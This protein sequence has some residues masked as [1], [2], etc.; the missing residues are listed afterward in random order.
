[1]EALMQAM[2]QALGWTLIH[3]LWEGTLIALALW[4][5][6]FASA[7][8]RYAAASFAMLAM[9]A[10][11]ALTLAR[12]QPHVDRALSPLPALPWSRLQP[13]TG[14]SAPVPGSS[15]DFLQW[16]APLWMS[17][18]VLFSLRSIA[19]CLAAQ[20]LRRVG[21]CSAPE[22]WQR[23]LGQLAARIRLSRPVWLLESCL[24]DVPVV[25]G[26]L[27]PAILVPAGLLT[28]FPPA[29]VECFL[30]HELAHI[31][32]WDYLV[33]I[34]QC[35]A[36]DLL[37][38]HPA[39]WW[40]SGLIRAER[41]NCC[42]DVV[43]A[44]GDAHGFAAALAALE[45]NRSAVRQPALAATGG[46]L[47]NRVRRLLGQPESRRSI[48]VPVL[49]AGALVASLAIAIGAPARP[50]AQVPQIPV[51]AEPA[52]KAAPPLLAQAPPS[53]RP[54]EP[55][56]LD[57][58]WARPYRNWLDE[59]VVYIISDAE[60]VAFRRLRA[61]AELQYFIEQFWLRRDPTPGTPENEYREEHYRRIAYVNDRF[62]YKDVPGWKTERGAIYIRFGPPD[63]LESLG[64]TPSA[65]AT[66]RW[67]YR[68]IEGVGTSVILEF[69]DPTGTGEF[70]M[71]R[72]PSAQSA[73]APPRPAAPPAKPQA[74]A[75]P[76]RPAGGTRLDVIPRAAG[77]V[78]A[79]YVQDQ[80]FVKVGQPLALLDLPAPFDKIY[81]PIDGIVTGLT[82]RVGDRL[83]RGQR[84]LQ[85]T[86]QA[87][88][89]A[90][91]PNS[92]P[93]KSQLPPA[94]V[95]PPPPSA[96][97]QPAPPAPRLPA[98][99][100]APPVPRPP[101]SASVQAPVMIATGTDLPVVAITRSGQ[102]Y[103]NGQP[104]K[105][106]GL[107]AS[108]IRRKFKTNSVYLLGDRRAPYD[109]VVQVVSVLAKEKF[110]IKLVAK[111]E[112]VPASGVQERQTV[113]PPAAPAPAPLP[114]PPPLR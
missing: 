36:E 11:F 31:R 95:Q 84:L 96:P 78:V 69:I 52:Q 51:P 67:R 112:D 63:E 33:N 50:P 45:H 7:R 66:E 100:P 32:R 104:V 114:P 27:R 106:I 53:V 1:M 35:V 5:F 57:E 38:Y 49:L 85:I 13:A 90:S 97:P 34:L 2:P 73:P 19:S 47:V 68:Y 30:L 59:E 54:A 94:V 82:A 23:K 71:T 110:E 60:R 91:A 10:A 74:A 22:H 20:R 92:E 39:V 24:T 64:A 40:V 25:V 46:R 77:T 109:A 6:R 3:F 83:Q 65:P 26:W 111:P 88:S 56:I 101:E 29:Q 86:P 43:A 62:G 105:N 21:V 37:F 55:S 16:L 99:V 28:G 87:P 8:V 98:A 89:A 4:V 42:D 18:A 103:L 102:L 76:S 107:L 80:Q 14:A 81:T 93:A 108:D 70:H 72:D 75:L 79:L 48:L 9:L 58:P 41:E 113:P 44:L 61:E 15:A 12:L 17:G